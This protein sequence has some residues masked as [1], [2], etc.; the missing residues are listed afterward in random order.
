MS[1]NDIASTMNSIMSSQQHRDIF[2]KG[3]TK[4]AAKKDEKCP[5]KCNGDKDKCKCKKDCKCKDKGSKKGKK[6]LNTFQ[7]C[8]AGLAN[9]SK[10]LDDAKFEKAATYAVLALDALV[11]QAEE[12]CADCGSVTDDV[13]SAKDKPEKKEDKE[14]K[15]DKKDEEEED[16]EDEDEGDNKDE[17]SE[18]EEDEE[19]EEEEDENDVWNWFGLKKD[20]ETAAPATNTQPTPAP[21]D[22]DVKDI[23]MDDVVSV[24]ERLIKREQGDVDIRAKM[25]ENVGEYSSLEP[26]S[27]LNQDSRSREELYGVA[28]KS[29]NSLIALAKELKKKTDPKAKVR[30]RPSAIFESTHSKVKDKKDHFPIDTIGRARNALARANQFD[31]APEWWSGSLKELKNAVVRAV[32]G[33]YPSIKVTEKSK[34]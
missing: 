25:D 24:L 13:L 14:D 11:K 32:K 20:K 9:I 23:S 31:S 3:I 21:D 1:K 30:N 27:D 10:T 8:V 28:S 5:C 16:D 2:S 12:E 22:S 18:D 4:T 17:D 19:D 6:G 26:Q 15:E 33:K 7:A 34:S 29:A